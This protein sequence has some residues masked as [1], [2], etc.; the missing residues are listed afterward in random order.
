[1]LLLCHLWHLTTRKHAVTESCR[2]SVCG[3]LAFMNLRQR[4]GRLS[5][6]CKNGKRVRCVHEGSSL[7]CHLLCSYHCALLDWI[8]ATN[9]MFV[10]LDIRI[11]VSM[12]AA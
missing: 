5:I 2:R 4:L 12:L 3:V 1:M 7:F 11:E 10:E 8:E 9:T 6:L